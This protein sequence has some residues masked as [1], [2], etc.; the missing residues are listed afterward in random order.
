MIVV[1]EFR[2]Y[3]NDKGFEPPLDIDGDWLAVKK[4]VESNSSSAETAPMIDGLSRYLKKERE[5]AWESN[6][7]DLKRILS[8][9]WTAW[10][11]GNRGRYRTSLIGDPAVE[12]RRYR[13]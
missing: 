10:F 7:S 12:P 5:R 6:S 1:A 11:E 9:E 4:F 2:K 3:L 8:I 13:R